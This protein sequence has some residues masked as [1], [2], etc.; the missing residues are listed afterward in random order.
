M[1]YTGR[2]VGR[3]YA[4]A[5][6]W[7]MRAAER[8]YAL[9]E[10]DLGY[11]YEQG[12]GVPLDYVAAYKWYSVGVAGGDDR[13][14]AR[15]K[16]LSRLMRPREVTEAKSLAFAHVLRHGKDRE[17]LNNNSKASIFDPP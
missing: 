9:A 3:D 13:G 1:Y 11:L 4:E 17:Q 8:G 7:T 15:M 16:A 6:K 14:I 5:A 2:G 12:K 10:T